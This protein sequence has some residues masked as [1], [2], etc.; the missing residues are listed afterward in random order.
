M[1]RIDYPRVREIYEE[2]IATRMATFE[3]ESVDWEEWNVKMLPHSR[4]VL[5]EG[6]EVSGWA[7]L[8]GV[9]SRCVYQGVAEV[10][11]YVAEN[12]RG[13]GAG[14]K[15]LSA[16]IDSAESAGIWTLTAGIFPENKA[17]VELHKKFGFEVLGTRKRIGKLDGVW[18]DTLLLERRSTVI[19]VE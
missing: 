5:R 4:L 7:A 6:K 10:S 1:S 12:R 16:L 2:G 15:L 19:G 9:S 13:H 11:V 18:R 14:K 3:T 8:S 17:S